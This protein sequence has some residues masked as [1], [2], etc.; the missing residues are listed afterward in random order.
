MVART[1]MA[2]LILRLRN[3]ADAGTAEWT[4]D[5]TTYW[6]DDLLEDQL[7]LHV[8]EYREE[9]PPIPEAV[10]GDTEYHKYKLAYRNIEEATSGTAHWSIRNTQGTLQGTAGYSVNYEQGL[11]TFT[12]DT[13]GSTMVC[14]YKAYD[15]PASAANIWRTRAANVHS[16]Y[17][18]REGEHS[19]SR[20]EW[21]DHCL[22][23]ADLMDKQAGQAGNLTVRM[24]RS[25]LA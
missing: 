18:I 13:A 14:R 5:A 17:S 25:D 6:A 20:A 7:D 15:L 11:V 12:A 22:K 4:K 9:V 24:Y 16:Y 8:V 3:L 19:L 21:F 23:M 1:G 10:D 2:A